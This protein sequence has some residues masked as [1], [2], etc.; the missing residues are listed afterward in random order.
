MKTLLL[1][2]ALFCSATVVP[3]AQAAIKARGSDSTLHVVK[4]LAAAFEA[5]TGKKLAL[6]GGGSGAGAK[7]LAAG[8]ISLAFLSR[9]L[10]DAEKASGLSGHAYAKDG[11][12]VIVHK[13]NAVAGLTVAELKEIFTGKTGAWADGKSV[14]AFN[15]NTDSGTREVFQE[16]VL[17]KEAFSPK[18]AVKHDG[19]LIGSVEK[20]PAAVAYT[21]LG[22]VDPGKVRVVPVAGVAP[23]TATLKDGSYPIARTP[24]LATK[25]AAAGDEKEFVDFVLG[26]KGQAIVAKQGLVAIK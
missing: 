14:V 5:E 23:S 9:E 6:E 22:E 17:G 15:R 1:L 19:V 26:P 2:A 12:A 3:F 24:T 8:E 16:R 4:A 25:G 11:V 18:V 20:I 7:A 13:D 21:S 10:T